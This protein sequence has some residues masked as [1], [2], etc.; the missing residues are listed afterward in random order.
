MPTN[1]AIGKIHL[2]FSTAPL[3][4]D[5]DQEQLESL[6]SYQR[7]LEKDTLCWSF[8]DC[9]ELYRESSRHLA[10][11]MHELIAELKGDLGL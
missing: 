3:P 10:T 4:S 8:A 9:D 1:L 2:Y 6:R 5:F 7:T 11:V